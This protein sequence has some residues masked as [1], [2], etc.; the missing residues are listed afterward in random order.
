MISAGLLTLRREMRDET[1]IHDYDGRV[2]R[3]IVREVYN[4]MVREELC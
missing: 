3:R 2:L 4:A 1:P